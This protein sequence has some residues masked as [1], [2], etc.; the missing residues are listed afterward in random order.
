[1]PEADTGR[2]N[3]F[4]ATCIFL[5]GGWIHWI[6]V[7]DWTISGSARMINRSVFGPRCVTR[8]QC[9]RVRSPDTAPVSRTS[10]QGHGFGTDELLPLGV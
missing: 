8:A 1:M 2:N 5:F 7:A 10:A 3:S 6:S 4:A 9:S